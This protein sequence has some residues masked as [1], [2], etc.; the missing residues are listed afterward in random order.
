MTGDIHK[1]LIVLLQH[2]RHRA[3]RR[4]EALVQVRAI[5]GERDIA[6]HD[7]LDL[8]SRQFHDGNAG[9]AQL[10][11]QLLGLMVHVSA[12]AAAGERANARADQGVF[13]HL[14]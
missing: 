12:D 8:V 1:R 7:E 11:S 14:P 13:L 2:F 3:K 6:R 10:R 9:A 4:V 5:R